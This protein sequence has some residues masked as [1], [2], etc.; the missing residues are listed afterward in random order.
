MLNRFKILFIFAVLAASS[1]A[2][3][4]T[5]QRDVPYTKALYTFIDRYYNNE[6]PTIAKAQELYN[7][8]VDS[9]PESFDDYQQAVHFAR[10]EFYLGMCIM[11]E[12]DFS[13]IEK[14]KSMTDTT[15]NSKNL[16]EQVKK[17][18]EQAA[19]HFDSAI[20]FAQAALKIHEGPD[21]YVIYAMGISSNCTVKNSSYVINNG[22]K[23]GSFSKKALQLDAQ[24][25][26]ACYYQNAQDL[27]APPFFA[28][29]KRGYN[30]MLSF[31]NNE[32]LRKEK[33]DT[34]Y[35]IT[36]IAFSFY[37]TNNKENA[38]IWYKKSLEIYPKNSFAL[39][40]I[41]ELSE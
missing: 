34:Y 3:S 23:V 26:T 27:F 36:A 22:L 33:F 18:K 12:Y 10:C 5:A 7:A 31:Y 9:L 21:A 32:N 11:G 17:T 35:F 16:S 28:N 13:S 20:S 15:D 2:F 37:K 14:I 39:K 30:K 4:Q 38:L 29:Y 41:K 8:A 1:I 40:M 19:S 25:A 24:N 6:I